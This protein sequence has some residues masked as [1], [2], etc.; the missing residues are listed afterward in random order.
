MWKFSG[1]GYSLRDKFSI[2]NNRYVLL[3]NSRIDPVK[4]HMI[5]VEAV[6]ELPKEIKEKIVVVCTG[7]KGGTYYHTLVEKIEQYGLCEQFIF[8]GWVDPYEI[9]SISDFLF[10]PSHKEGFALNIAEAF[11][12]KLPAART[13]TCGWE[14]LKIGCLQIFPDRTDE[15]KDII[16]KLVLKGKKTFSEQIE[17]A[18]NFANENLTVEVMTKN[19]VMVYNETIEVCYGKQKREGSTGKNP[20]HNEI[21]R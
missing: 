7:K 6:N 11:F 4:N 20:R 8:V 19:T 3:L 15:I 12:M 2:P 13:A 21:H 18:Y 17:R 14:D 5:M 10:L 9:S 16:V 1:G